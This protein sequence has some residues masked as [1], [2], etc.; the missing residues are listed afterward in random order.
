MVEPQ[1]TADPNLDKIEDAILALMREIILLKDVHAGEGLEPEAYPA[2]SAT[3][4]FPIKGTEQ[5]G[6]LVEYRWH[7]TCRL[8][9]DY[10]D[11]GYYEVYKSLLIAVHRK[12][13]SNPTL[14]ETCYRHDVEDS[15]PAIPIPG[16]GVLIKT[17]EVVAEVE[18]ED[19]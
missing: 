6:G 7:W 8:Y 2:F 3:L 16:R 13:L 5:T 19:V 17:F 12:F 10:T 9:L 15:G 1:L 11:P 18:E 14:K 4:G